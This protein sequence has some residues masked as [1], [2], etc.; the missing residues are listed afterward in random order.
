MATATDFGSGSPMLLP[1]QVD[2]N[3]QT[4]HLM[5]A[6][7]KD[8]TLYL[9]D[10]DNL[11]QFNA[12]ANQVYQALNNAL[13]GGLYSAPAYFN[14]SVYLADAGGTLK[15]YTLSQAKLSAA[16]SYQSGANFSYPGSAPAISANGSSNGIVWTL[17]RDPN[18]AAVLHAFN[19]ANL[20]QEY[21]NSG[22]AANG[23][24]GFGSGN[25]FLTPVIAD[26]KV[27]VGTPGG[28][29]AFGSR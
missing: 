28:V 7:G 4:R 3:G 22:Q 18:N 25:K 15:A 8:G 1:D 5:V 17:Q 20:A 19:P 26:G 29:V 2:A 24:D 21:Y 13:P 27:L 11:G 12:G 9:L 16:P 6:A 10:R 23:R 14:G